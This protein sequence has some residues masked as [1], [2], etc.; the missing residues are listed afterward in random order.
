MARDNSR[1]VDFNYAK[2]QIH[3]VIDRGDE[4]TTFIRKIHA[5]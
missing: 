2:I 1:L 3:N 4:G 5:G